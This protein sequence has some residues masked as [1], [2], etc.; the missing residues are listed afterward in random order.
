[1]GSC[2]STTTVVL[3]CAFS[4]GGRRITCTFGA[5]AHRR[6]GGGVWGG[7]GVRGVVIGGP[8]RAGARR[9]GGNDRGTF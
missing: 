8:A 9:S 7:R 6:D 5:G 3:V 2:S 1:M 4:L